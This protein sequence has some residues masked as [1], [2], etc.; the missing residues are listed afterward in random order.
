MAFSVPLGSLA[1]HDKASSTDSSASAFA[2]D[3]A[4]KLVLQSPLC[5]AVIGLVLKLGGAVVCPRAL[6]RVH[7]RFLST[8]PADLDFRARL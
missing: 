4:S 8:Y 7:R 6:I 2:S 3:I 1:I 5:R